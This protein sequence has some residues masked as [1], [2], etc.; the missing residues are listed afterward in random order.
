MVKRKQIG[1][2]YPKKGLPNLL[3][4]QIDHFH[5]FMNLYSTPEEKKE[6]GF[7][8]VFQSYFP[9]E[10]PRTGRRIEFVDYHIG[11]PIFSYYECLEREM[12][13]LVPIKGRFRLISEGDKEEQ[14]EDVYLGQFPYMTENGTFIVNGK[15]QAV[16]SQTVRSYGVFFSKKR[17]PKGIY[18]FTGKIIPER[19]LWLEL[20]IASDGVLYFYIDRKKK[21]PF[22][23]FLRSIG[24]GSDK[25]L[26][27]FF[28]FSE[29]VIVNKKS[30][31]KNKGRI[32]A[33]PIL[34]VMVDEFV[35]EV[36]GE[37][38]SDSSYKVVLDR[39]NVIDDSN[40]DTI[41][42]SGDKTILLNK[43]KVL[44]PSQQCIYKT[45][46]KDL[47]NSKEDAATFVYEQL[48]GSKAPD[49]N[50]AFT[51]IENFFFSQKKCDLGKIGRTYLNKKL[52]LDISVDIH[53][54]TIQDIYALTKKM[55]SFLDGEPC[56]DDIDSLINRRVRTVSEQLYEVYESGVVRLAKQVKEELINSENFSIIRSVSSQHIVTAV[57]TFHNTSPCAQYL[58]EVNKVSHLAHTRRI[59]A[60]SNMLSRDRA[61][62]NVRDIHY[63]QHSRICLSETPEGAHVGIVTALALFAVVDENGCIKAPY[64][65]VNKGYIDLDSLVYLSAE[66]EENFVVGLG[67]VEYDKKTGKILVEKMDATKSATFISV[68]P[69]KIDFIDLIPSQYLG[70]SA[71]LIPSIERNE[72]TRTLIASNMQRQALPL[73]RPEVPIVGTGIEEKICKDFKGLPIAKRD[74]K[75]IYVDSKK[76]IILYNSQDGE[77]NKETFKLLKLFPTNQ[78]TCIHYK[79]IVRKGDTVKEG[80]VLCEGFG[81]KG[82]ELALGT[83][84]K[85]AVM[86]DPST[87]EDCFSFSNDII[88]KEKLTVLRT[89]KFVSDARLTKLGSEKFTSDITN[90]K[91]ENV[92]HLDENGLP[93]VGTSMYGNKIVIGKVTPVESKEQSPAMN[94]LDAIFNK[95]LASEKNVSVRYPNFSTPGIVVHS[96]ML[97]RIKM[98]PDYRKKITPQ[99]NTLKKKIISSMQKLHQNLEEKIIQ[100]VKGEKSRSVFDFSGRKL[101]KENDT[102][103]NEFLKKHLFY[104]EKDKILPSKDVRL[105]SSFSSY[106]WLQNEKKNKKLEKYLLNYDSR[107]KKIVCDYK[108]QLFLWEVGTDLA[109]GIE[110]KA[111]V[112][113]VQ[114]RDPMPGDK[115]ATNHGNKGVKGV[116]REATDMPFT[117]DGES[118]DLI[119]SAAGCIARMNLGQNL[120]MMLARLGKQKGERYA[121]PAFVRHSIKEIQKQLKEVGDDPSCCQKLYDG[122]SGEPLDNAVFVGN[123]YCIRL[124]HDAADKI[125]ARSTGPYSIIYQQPLRGRE[126]IGGQRVG[127]LVVP[128]ILAHGCASISREMMTIKSDDI[129]GRNKAYGSIIRGEPI[130]NPS[131]PEAFKVAMMLIRALSLDPRFLDLKTLKD[132]NKHKYE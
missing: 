46:L 105:L 29:E 110:E 18:I 12:S 114:K 36:T 70:L 106:H 98:S 81:T 28:D 7:Y 27:P 49:Y 104:K 45:L 68:S 125:H 113:V 102:V 97:K 32:L 62:I 59:T 30:L 92:A 109:P 37:V 116:S 39:G 77:E 90:E 3:S 16:I 41:L 51:F 80:D 131:T 40:I 60:I 130:P 115:F 88:R 132:Y 13:Y 20:V 123:I 54:L 129:Q 44:S 24:L 112:I 14:E 22:T 75:V 58:E 52:G 67:D 57:K 95:S 33:T 126:R 96:K 5:S 35:D 10:D 34:S 120:E 108:R 99:I 8:K 117:E 119:I 94:L 9:I 91:N 19:G 21:I 100:L 101:L 50:T 4:H 89:K 64:R 121:L 79:P 42:Q 56:S 118:I 43:N 69:E 47:N 82:G 71:N 38:I 65:R 111:K 122:T 103:S 87:Y 31:Q 23:I 17:H 63:T 86:I 78:N 11:V 66:D 2:A 83:N 127:E 85:V 25:E 93:M 48:R 73:I 26:L 128:G 6:S 55:L 1:V 76:I 84:L 107:Y 61:G 74:G 15:Q 124:N 53:N 72:A